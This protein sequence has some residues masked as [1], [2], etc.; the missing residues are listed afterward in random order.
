V[1]VKLTKE[2]AKSQSQSPQQVQI[3]TIRMEPLESASTYYVNH[4]EIASSLH[5]FSI[6][7][8]RLPGKLSADQVEEVN[9][10]GSLVIEPEVQVIIPS[11]LIIGPIRALTT[12]KGI[13]EETYGVKLHEI[14]GV[15]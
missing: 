14:G 2:Q 6:I 4:V 1:G 7:C 11:T 12:Q 8:G 13:Y 9:S 15:K 5:D 3:S 10:S